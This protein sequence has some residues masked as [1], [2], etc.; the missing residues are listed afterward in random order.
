MV[1][2]LALAVLQ[3][4][5]ALAEGATRILDC[6]IVKVCDAAGNCEPASEHVSFRM[7]PKE[8]EAGGAGTYAIRYG[9]IETQ[10]NALS[11]L[12]PFLWTVGTERDALMI[13]SESQWLWHELKVEPQPMAAIRFLTCSFQ[14]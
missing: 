14:Q 3:S 1:S 12:G 8:L 13:S 5:A 2:G 9:D 11:E 4:Q 6:S 10:M 7:D